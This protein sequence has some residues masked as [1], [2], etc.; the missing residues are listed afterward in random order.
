MKTVG[1]IGGL[2]PETT[3]QFYMQII[4]LC[5]KKNKTSRP[6]ILISNVPMPFALEEKFIKQ[7]K[8]KKEFL[9]LLINSARQLEKGGADF[10]V[11]P[12]NTA[13]IFI[14][15]IKTSVSIPVLSI[16]EETLKI[17]NKKDVKK[18]GLLATPATVKNKLF[19][20]NIDVVLPSK[21]DQQKMGFIINK[22]INNHQTPKD[23]Q[24]LF[25]IVDAVSKNSD[26]ILLAC[27][28]LQLLIPEKKHNKIEIFDTMKI[29]A[30]A[31]ARE[32]L[33]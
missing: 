30:D 27:T 5:Q 25:R 1:I 29:L 24:E 2:G 15:E 12:C 7:G 9:S 32:L 19:D 33:H 14:N 11:I 16:I 18:T 3:A 4:S 28:D 22:L 17:L 31:T 10:I 26:A 8:G 23:K 20:K 6:S 13:H 21:T